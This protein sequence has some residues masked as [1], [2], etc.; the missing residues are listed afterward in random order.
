[1]IDPRGIEEGR[2]KTKTENLSSYKLKCSVFGKLC[3]QSIV[4]L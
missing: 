3:N 4:I 1:M 2:T